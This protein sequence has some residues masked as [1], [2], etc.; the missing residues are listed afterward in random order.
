M[1]RQFSFCITTL[2]LFSTFTSAATWQ[3][4]DTPR[5]KATIL[6]A[7]D[8]DNSVAYASDSVL[9]GG[10]SYYL[11]YDGTNWKNVTL[12]PSPKITGISGNNIV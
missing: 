5:A 9:P 2:I 10:N 11:V 12:P 7:I 3:V 8:G 1:K 4:V 6:C